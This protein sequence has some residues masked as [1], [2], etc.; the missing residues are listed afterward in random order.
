MDR[1]VRHHNP[2]CAQ[3]TTCANPHTVTQSL[4]T[5]AECWSAIRGAASHVDV[6]SNNKH[7][8]RPSITMAVIYRPSV[9][10]PVRRYTTLVTYLMMDRIGR[11]DL[12]GNLLLVRVDLRGR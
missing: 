9:R 8:R 11:G 10:P 4:A 1:Y 6:R 5:D 12:P 3:F 2:I 7:A